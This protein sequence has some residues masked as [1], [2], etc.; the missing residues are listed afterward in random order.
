MWAVAIDE[1]M[2]KNPRVK[3]G[4]LKGCDDQEWLDLSRRLT[5][6]FQGILLGKITGKTP[7]NQ[8]YGVQT[9]YVICN[10]KK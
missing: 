9:M 6:L 10:S 1:E 8:G 7:K 5:V 4:K 3:I 2:L